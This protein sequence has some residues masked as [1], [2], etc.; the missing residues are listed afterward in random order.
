MEREI[1]LVIGTREI[2]RRN[3]IKQAMKSTGLPRICFKDVGVD[4]IRIKG[5]R[6]CKYIDA[7][8]CMEDDNHTMDKYQQM[9]IELKIGNH[10]KLEV[11]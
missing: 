6:D 3:L 5:F 8:T 7:G 11:K 1:I 4:P 9:A 10:V 2:N